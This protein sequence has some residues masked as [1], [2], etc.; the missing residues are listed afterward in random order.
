MMGGN[1][2]SSIDGLKLLTQ[3]DKL[4]KIS[5]IVSNV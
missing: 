3:I 4:S 2:S 5:E 1:V